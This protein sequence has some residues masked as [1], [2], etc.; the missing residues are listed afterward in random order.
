M[1]HR[2]F[3]SQSAF[4]AQEPK[5]LVYRRGDVITLP[6]RRK[7]ERVEMDPE[8]RER[9]SL[10]VQQG[11]ETTVKF[12]SQLEAW[13]LWQ[14]WRVS[15]ACEMPIVQVCVCVCVCVCVFV[16]CVVCACVYWCVRDVNAPSDHTHFERI[17]ICKQVICS[18]AQLAE[19]L[20]PVE[21]RPG[22]AVTTINAE[23]VT[24][25]N[26]Y[27]IRVI[28]PRCIATSVLLASARTFT[29]QRH[30]H[31]AHTLCFLAS[32]MREARTREVQGV[33]LW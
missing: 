17:T 18:C 13:Y 31:T 20:T 29:V 3:L 28:T 33:S 19:S 4:F 8:V 23:L 16:V 7:Y 25:D 12:H 14:F 26:R 5:P 32:A 22:V 6:T 15:G 9:P 24:K 11:T 21:V 30:T 27:T 10:I 2:E 1:F